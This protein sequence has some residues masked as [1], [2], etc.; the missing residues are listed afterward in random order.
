MWVVNLDQKASL[1]P[2]PTTTPPPPLP[3]ALSSLLHPPQGTNPSFTL[4]PS[5]PPLLLLPPLVQPPGQAFG[6]LEATWPLC[7]WRHSVWRVQTPARGKGL[8]MSCQLVRPQ[9]RYVTAR[10]N[11]ADCNPLQANP[12]WIGSHPYGE[13]MELL[14]LLDV[15]AAGTSS[16]H[17]HC[18]WKLV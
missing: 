9:G 7:S 5:F 1:S 17:V 4:P 12:F 16:R 10:N 13:T 6:P 18:T 8:M 2:P 3:S 15:F 14:L 11:M